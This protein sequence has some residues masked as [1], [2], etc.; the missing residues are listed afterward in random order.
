VN[1]IPAT[2]W[3]GVW[4]ALLLAGCARAEHPIEREPAPRRP[5]LRLEL[6]QRMECEQAPRR[7]LM[8]RMQAEGVGSPQELDP[9]RDDLL[10][11]IREEDTANRMWLKK[12]L[13]ESGWPGRS[14]VGVDGAHA[15]WLLV[16]HAD[17]DRP[18]QKE[19]LQLMETAPAGEVAGDDIAYLTDRVRLA[20]GRPQ[21]YGTQLEFRDGEWVPRPI[22]DEEHIDQRRKDRGLPPL[23]EYLRFVRRLPFSK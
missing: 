16:Q 21:L 4:L 2:I 23:A 6:L 8:Q 5:E 7:E 12:I 3:R 10:Q 15:A 22:E 17:T 1:S 20:D 18:F 13:A 14:L 9:L 11:V 19:C